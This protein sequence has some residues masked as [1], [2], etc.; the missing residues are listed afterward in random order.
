MITLSDN[1]F[2][3]LTTQSE[4]KAKVAI[5]TS[6][7]FEIV[8]IDKNGTVTIQLLACEA[9]QINIYYTIPPPGMTEGSV[10]MGECV[11]PTKSI[12]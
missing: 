3:S 11:V 1:K 4:Q 6:D 8:H 5:K 7:T 12:I 10:I 9:E 2:S